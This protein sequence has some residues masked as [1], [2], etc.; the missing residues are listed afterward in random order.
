[1]E[2]QY[3]CK[4]ADFCRVPKEQWRWNLLIRT[5]DFVTQNE[6]DQAAETL[7]KR[8]KTASVREVKLE[9]IT[10]GRCVQMLHIGPYD[11]E[12]ETIALMKAHAEKEGFTFHGRHHE[13]Y[14]SDPRRVAPE[15]LKT[16]LRIPIKM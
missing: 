16:I 11:R 7:L 2:G 13:I 4:K 5:P 1:L 14:L 15:R 8:G 12:P 9:T 6:L 3:W 10:E